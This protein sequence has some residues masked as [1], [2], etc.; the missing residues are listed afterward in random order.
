MN[1]SLYIARHLSFGR[2]GR[3]STPAVRVATT[4]IALSVAVMLA[5]IAVV[6]GFKREITEKVTGFNSHILLS[7]DPAHAR[8]SGASDNLLILDPAL[9]KILDESPGID[10]YA[11]QSSM[12]A[13]LK[14]P[15]DFKG[16][17]LKGVV[18]SAQFRFLRRNLSEGYIPAFESDSDADKVVI[19]RLAAS[20]LGLKLGSDIDTYFITDDVRV[21]RL[22]VAGIYDSHFEAYDDVLAFGDL[23]TINR[24]ADLRPGQASV[25]QITVSDFSRLDDITD[26]LQ[27]N[28]I[29]GLKNGE[30]NTVYRLDNAHSSG[31]GYFRWLSLLDM[32]VIVILTL[33][34]AV[35]CI[36]LVSGMLIMILD[37]RRFIGLMK[38]L[39]MSTRALRKVFVY[40]AVR[41]T[42]R[43]LIIGNAIGLGLLW[44]QDRTHFIP[45]DAESYYIDFVPVSI[46]WVDV[47]ALNLGV[48]VIVYLVLILPSRFVAR[49]SPAETMRSE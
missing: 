26:D 21:R 14:T 36:T 18:D 19:S 30:I 13:I 3:S 29:E 1:T 22:K 48:L 43:G 47:L 38:A 5:S 34:I 33:M 31:A 35:G 41:V 42:I 2:D 39:G 49:I 9:E 17:Y 45:L 40:L 46:N 15:T 20:Q 16:I 7:V 4:A 8:A 32:N 11:L 6:S 23:S 25:M 12:P 37:K 28:L 24:I 10:Q 44:I 27:Q